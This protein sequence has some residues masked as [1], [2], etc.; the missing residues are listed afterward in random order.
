MNELFKAYEMKTKAAYGQCRHIQDVVADSSR[1]LHALPP[2]AGLCVFK[3][4]GSADVVLRSDCYISTIP[5]P[6][7]SHA[8]YL[9][10]ETVAARCPQEAK[11]IVSR[12][13]QLT[14]RE[15]N[16]ESYHLNTLHVRFLGRRT[17]SAQVDPIGITFSL[18]TEPQADD[19]TD[20]DWNL[21]DELATEGEASPLQLNLF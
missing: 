17:L 21:V 10:R 18:H 6:A 16:L 5:F 7:G 15:R 1:T 14:Q 9:I 13:M 11:T 3:V 20:D 8:T 19:H 12:Y 2:E 4:T